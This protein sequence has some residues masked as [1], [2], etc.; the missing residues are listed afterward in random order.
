MEMKSPPRTAIGNSAGTCS[1]CT[2][3][4]CRSTS[5][6]AIADMKRELPKN[7][8]SGAGF[9]AR[10]FQNRRSLGKADGERSG[11]EKCAEGKLAG[12]EKEGREEEGPGGALRVR[13]SVSVHLV[14][15]SELE[16]DEGA[17]R[18]R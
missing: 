14:P 16:V 15:A 18:V 1:P 8:M 4:R 11:V 12:E 10:T 9:C 3:R 13:S 2:S 17:T 6:G 7:T 5:A